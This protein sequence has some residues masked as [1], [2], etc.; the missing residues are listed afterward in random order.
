MRCFLPAIGT[1][2]ILVSHNFSFAQRL[3]EGALRG[4]NTVA[5]VVL[6]DDSHSGSLSNV[7]SSITT[8]VEL[9]LRQAGVMVKEKAESIFAVE[10]IILEIE[11]YHAYAVDISLVERIT[12]SRSGQTVHS[13]HSK[14]WYRGPSAGAER[15]YAKLKKHI[16][17]GVDAFLNDWLADNQE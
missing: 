14:I 17:D 4:L 1:L 3:N 2:L 12:F 16:L 8:S 6:F 9:R 10:V 13:P 5:V 15:G 7:K 11:D